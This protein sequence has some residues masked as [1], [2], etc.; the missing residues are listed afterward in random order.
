M[1]EVLVD[2]GQLFLERIIQS[3]NDFRVALHG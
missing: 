3:G 1:E 2:G